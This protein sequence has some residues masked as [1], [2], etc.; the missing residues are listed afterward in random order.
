MVVTAN[1]SGGSASFVAINA[2]GSLNDAAETIRFEGQGKNPARQTSPH[3]H[4]IAF[5]P[6]GKH[7]FATDLGTDKIHKLKKT[8]SNAFDDANEDVTLAP[9]SGPRHLI[10]NNKCTR[11]YLI[12]EISGM[13]TVFAVDA[14]GNLTE[15]QTTLADTCHAEGSADIHLSP[16]EKFLYASTR[17]KGD[18]IVIFKVESDGALT[19]A[20]YQPTG[21]HPR[22]FAIT[23]DGSIMLVACRNSGMIQIFKI[24]KQ[25]GLL[26][27]SGKKIEVRQPVFIKL[28]EQ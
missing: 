10:F 21:R 8:L 22:N 24:D 9:G 15:I 13:A 12:N 11:A 16:D 20:G 26:T 28:V 25:T 23:P 7:I 2:D 1:Y 4:C 5:A 17:L 19:R 27:D 14:A 6:D 3:V 18:G